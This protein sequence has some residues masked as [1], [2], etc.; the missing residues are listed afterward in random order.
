MMKDSVQ[1]I[2]DFCGYKQLA[3]GL[4][5]ALV[6]Y[7]L[8]NYKHYTS[9]KLEQ[10]F[11]L[12]AEGKLGIELNK[13]HLTGMEF[14]KVMSAFKKMYHSSNI[15]EQ[16]EEKTSEEEIKRRLVQWRKDFQAEYKKF[17]EKKDWHIY[18]P[19]YA[20]TW[21]NENYKTSI[22]WEKFESEARSKVLIHN[23]E[24]RKKH[25]D[26]AKLIS[27]VL[28]DPL[29]GDD[30]ARCKVYCCRLAIKAFFE[31]QAMKGTNI[32]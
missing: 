9:E 12:A 2:I 28:V 23:K 31:E 27:N 15:Q 3:D 17:T 18:M 19:I 14:A 6:Q 11:H 13:Y 29:I 10:I 7:M 21:V 30:K 8:T 22:K 24:Y 32:L 16:K 4:M 26:E 5:T 25:T 20:W 1:K